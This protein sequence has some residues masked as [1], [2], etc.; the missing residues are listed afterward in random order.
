MAADIL[1]TILTTQQQQQPT[2]LSRA[3]DIAA[4]I[5]KGSPQLV[6][7]IMQQRNQ[8]FQAFWNTQGVPPQLIAS[9]L[10]ANAVSVFQHD[11]DLV[12][13]LAAKLKAI[14]ATDAQIA[15]SLPTLPA[16]Y[17]ATPNAD[18]TV[19]IAMAPIPAQ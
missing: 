13:F 7:G 9:A 15:Q 16:I 8:M 17:T 14:G 5:L 4:N 6:L 11:A 2:A 18:G 1:S 10:G 3:A 12:A 19:T